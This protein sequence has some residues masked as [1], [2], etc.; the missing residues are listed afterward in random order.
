MELEN[1]FKQHKRFV[2]FLEKTFKRFPFLEE[3]IKKVPIIRK[4]IEEEELKLEKELE[5]IAKPYKNTT[6]TYS[7]LPKK[8]ISKKKLLEFFFEIQKQENSKWEKGYVSGAVYHGEK[9]HIDFLNQVYS[10]FS[11]AN[12]LHSD[13]WPSISKFEAEIVSMCASL[14]NANKDLPPKEQVCGTVTSGGTESILLAIKTYRDWAYK[15]KK[16]KKPEILVPYTAHAAFDKASQYFKIKIKKLPVDENQKAVAKSIKKYIS[17]N[18]IAIVGSAPS[19]PHG[20]IDPIEEMSEY[21]YK[22]GIGFHTDA[23]LGGF[24]LPFADK[25]GYPV[26]LFDFRLR[27]VTSISIDPHKYGYASKGTSVILYRN[28]ALRK[29]QFFTVNDWPGGLYF[30][31]TIAGSRPGGLSAS[32]Y[33]SLLSIGEKGYLNSTKKILTT[34][35]EIKKG[36]Q[37]LAE[38]R[39]VGDPLWVISFT[40]DVLD[41]YQIS[42][43]MNKRNWNLNVLHR[44]PAIHI[45]ITLRHTQKGVA[46]RFIK[47]LKES[48]KY[49]K[50]NPE[51]KSMAPIYGIA[52]SIPMRSLV[53]DILKKYL[54]LLYRV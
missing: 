42:E 47:D 46:Q 44:P 51:K 33:A 19:F 20:V 5:K 49:A 48:V 16:I 14:L 53:D 22:E 27:G 1:L 18:T 30:S 9:N 3:Y 26:P 28:E 50:N 4:R 36:I 45:A 32:C 38:L 31:P 15:E 40:S 43:E 21:A 8:G 11:Q 41:I 13:L 35:E 23:C 2:K 7:S 6:I 39:I 29:Y 34:A 24:L 25:L 54:D 17:R 12:P 10:L 52:G 37:D